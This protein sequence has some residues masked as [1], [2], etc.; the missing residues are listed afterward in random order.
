L[1]ALSTLGRSDDISPSSLVLASDAA[2]IQAPP[3]ASP[4]QPPAAKEPGGVTAP[5]APLPEDIRAIPSPS[6]SPSNSAPEP[7]REE[8]AASVATTSSPNMIGDMGGNQGLHS[9][10]P[11][12]ARLGPVQYGSFALAPGSIAQTPSGSGILVTSATNLYGS[13]VP[14]TTFTINNLNGP[15]LPTAIPLTNNDSA[16]TNAAQQAL[17]NY[18]KTLNTANQQINNVLVNGNGALASETSPHPGP[19]Y[20]TDTFSIAQFYTYQYSIIPSYITINIP[21]PSGGVIGRQRISDNENVIPTDRVFCD[22]SYFHDAA[23]A[24]PSDANRL[25]PGFEKTFLDERMSVEMRFPMAVMESSNLVADSSSYGSTGQFGDLEVILKAIVLEEEAWALSMGLG[26]SIP[27]APG[28][29]VGLSDGTPL[30]KI[31]NQSTHLLPFFG[32]LVKPND[33][34]FAQVYVQIDV[35]ASGDSVFAN[36]NGNGLTSCG[37]I[38]DQTQIFVDAMLG[39]WLYRNP[40][41]RF[42]GLAA[43][44]EAHYTGGLNAP[45]AIQAGN[46]AIG[47]NSAEY[48]VLDLTVG[49]HAVVGNTTWTLGYAVPVTEDR[50]FEGELRF[51]VNRKF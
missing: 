32:L 33:D 24:S 8:S 48:N 3:A 7:S 47:N 43:V 18:Y 26:I 14:S 46:F 9:V 31:G 41:Q 38:Y 13:P 50:G 12:P 1:L 4:A 19:I 22:Y 27:T 21:S 25:V 16:Y 34:W 37:D 49:A 35:G 51:F 30:V 17:Y 5:F 10:L 36:V 15:V 20:P 2:P 42:S 44:V 28:V 39:R 29:N 23:L 45:S 11:M 6:N 40:A